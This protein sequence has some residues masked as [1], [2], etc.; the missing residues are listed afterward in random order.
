MTALRTLSTALAVAVGIGTL[1]CAMNAPTSSTGPA[2]HRQVL[3]VDQKA[4]D[5]QAADAAKANF[6]QQIFRNLP[7]QISAADAAKMLVRID[8]SK[9]KDKPDRK[10]QCLGCG[11]GGWGG[12]GGWGGGCCGGLGAFGFYS[13][14]ASYWSNM[15]YYQYASVYYPYYYSAPSGMFY[16][17]VWNGG[18]PFFQ[19]TGAG[20]SPYFA[21]RYWL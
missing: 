18:Y 20:Y 11:L 13:P 21:G 19:G 10:V 9:V 2:A 3:S 6:E 1:G 8:P 7:K 5:V 4:G 12:Y 14:W 17:Y 15:L 16:P